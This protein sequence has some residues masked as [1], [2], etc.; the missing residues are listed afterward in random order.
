[1][2]FLCLSGHLGPTGQI[3]EIFLSG[4]LH[5]KVLLKDQVLILPD[6][7]NLRFAAYGGIIK[8]VD[9]TWHPEFGLSTPNQC[10]ELHTFNMSCS[11]VFEWN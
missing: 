8:V 7:R 4:F 2:V 9:S 6:G 5:P 11:I 3:P 1:M 10:I